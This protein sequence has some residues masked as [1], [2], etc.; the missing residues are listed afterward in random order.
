MLE[1]PAVRYDEHDFKSGD[2]SPP[3]PLFVKEERHSERQVFRG[4]SHIHM[5]NML[6]YIYVY[7]Y[8]HVNIHICSYETPLRNIIGV[9]AGESTIHQPR[10]PGALPA[11]RIPAPWLRGFVG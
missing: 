8:V 3:S 7:I 4:E 11:T 5:Y 1:C 10:L 2:R 6:I 9:T